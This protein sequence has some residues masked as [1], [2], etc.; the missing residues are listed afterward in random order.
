M[1]EPLF[2]PLLVTTH[3]P[4]AR[5]LGPQYSLPKLPAPMRR[6]VP[7]I[8]RGVFVITLITPLSALA[9]QTADAGPRM[10]SIC[11]ISLVFEGMKSHMTNPKKSW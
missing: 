4:P 10:I 8:S 7:S 1:R 11:L 2:T 9:P 5:G 6:L 3:G